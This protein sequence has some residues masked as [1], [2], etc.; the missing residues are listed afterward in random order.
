MKT[1]ENQV[2]TLLGKMTLREKIGQMWQVSK[3]TDADRDL[4]RQGLIGSL[5]NITDP[6]LINEFQ[7]ISV[8]ETRM[9]IPLLIGRDVIH[10]FRTIFPIPLGQAAS[11]NCD[12]VQQSARVSAKEAS[13][14]G[15][16]WTFSP[17]V[18]VARDPRW[19]RV[20]EGGG[21][22]PLLAGAMGAAMVRGYQG[23]D[24]SHPEAI[25]ACAKHFAAYGATEGGRDYNTADVSERTLRET[26]LPP[27]KTCVDAGVATMMSGFHE[28][29]GIPSSAHAFCLRQILR[30]EWKFG[31]FVVSDYESIREMIIHGFCADSRE[32]AREA[33]LA[34]VDMEM[35][36][37]CYIDNLES[38]VASGEVPI[39][40]IDDSV[41]S[42]LR[43]KYQLG[44]FENAQVDRSRIASQSLEDHLQVARQMVRESCVLLRNEGSLIPLKKDISSIALIGPLADNPGDQFGC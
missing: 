10:G 1:V 3:G 20:A 9:G 16:R 39:S 13:A 41:R 31:G 43:L 4:V 35:S 36:S 23:E 44:L 28:L 8:N 7:R 33:V 18:D 19:G 22:D 14:C 5:L 30:E 27:F 42:I 12:L 25:A 38:L 6:V 40:C 15:I 21:E 17:M 29:S 24:L 26:Y 11:W 34:G 2:E 37:R 32:A